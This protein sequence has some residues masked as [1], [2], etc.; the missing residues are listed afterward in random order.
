MIPTDEELM[1]HIF[2]VVTDGQEIREAFE[3]DQE[4]ADEREICTLENFERLHGGL[5]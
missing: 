3:R 4:A 1:Q 5:L 2:D